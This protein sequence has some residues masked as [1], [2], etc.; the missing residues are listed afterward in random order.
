[1]F[2]SIILDL[3]RRFAINLNYHYTALSG[4]R[5]IP[6]SLCVINHFMIDRQLLYLVCL[7]CSVLFI[8]SL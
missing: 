3:G 8:S 4:Y 1:M 2:L 5:T 6:L 7:Y